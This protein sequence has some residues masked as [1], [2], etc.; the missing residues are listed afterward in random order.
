MPVKPVLSLF[1]YANPTI[2]EAVSSNEC[3]KQSCVIEDSS[4]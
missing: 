3:L 2:V 1:V 4:I